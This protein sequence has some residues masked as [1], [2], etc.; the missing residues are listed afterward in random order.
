MIDFTNFETKKKAY[1]GANGNKISIIYK[2]EIYMLKLPTHSLKNKSLSYTNSAISEYLGCSIFKMLGI[3]AQETILGKYVYHNVERIVVACKDFVK[4][5]EQLFD[6]ASVKNQIIDSNSNGYGTELDDILETIEKQS[7]IDT[8]L[9]KDRFWDMFVIDAL[10]G[11]WDRHNGNW[12][13]LYN[14]KEDSLSLA[15]IY[16]CGSCLFPQI[17]EGTIDKVLKSKQEQNARVF[18]V[19]T[20]A[21]IKNGAR[22]KYY[23]FF[24]KHEYKDCDNA[25][26]RISCKVNVEMI[27]NLIDGVTV[28][29]EKHK[30]FL[31][32]M[33]N[34]RYQNLLLKNS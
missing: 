33:I 16:D 26:K 5:G 32:L 2:N 22:I 7:V 8:K 3:D 24:A 9:L 4:N 12:G 18:D 6:F 27:N 17:D 15:P 31:K 14:Q 11:N 23:E 10:I 1:G 20:S 30:E 13:F 25:I 19:P 28:L 29:S 21:I 34:L